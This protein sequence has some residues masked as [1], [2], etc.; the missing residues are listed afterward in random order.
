MSKRFK[1]GDLVTVRVK[2][3]PVID[4]LLQ[5]NGVNAII[6]II[7]QCRY[8]NDIYLFKPSNS[9]FTDSA[10][11]VGGKDLLPYEG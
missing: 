4:K 7:T 9:P 1:K 8:K 10:Y 5:S 3:D 6:G 2:G 11:W